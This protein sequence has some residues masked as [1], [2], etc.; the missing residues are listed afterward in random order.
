[1]TRHG[2]FFCFSYLLYAWVEG[3]M[4]FW[5]A[6]G[7][8]AICLFWHFPVGILCSLDRFGF[9]FPLF[10]LFVSIMWHNGRRITLYYR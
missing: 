10:P 7:V 6:W 2:V 9:P 5:V 4:I 1:M 3:A 8:V